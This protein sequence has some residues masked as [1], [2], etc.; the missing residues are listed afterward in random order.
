MKEIGLTEEEWIN[1]WHREGCAIINWVILI[2]P[3]IDTVID[4]ICNIV[5]GFV[6]GLLMIVPVLVLVMV[7]GVKFLAVIDGGLNGV[8]FGE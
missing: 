8:N 4:F 3:I 6:Y 7:S 5:V 2:F 1:F